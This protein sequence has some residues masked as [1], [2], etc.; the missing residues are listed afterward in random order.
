MLINK[1]YHG[2]LR[3]KIPQPFSDFGLKSSWPK[4]CISASLSNFSL[5]SANKNWMKLTQLRHNCDICNSFIYRL[6]LNR[7]PTVVETDV[8]GDV[9]TDDIIYR[10]GVITL[11][12]GW[13]NG[14]VST[15]HLFI[16][17]HVYISYIIDQSLVLFPK[18]FRIWEVY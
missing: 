8:V 18:L 2:K 14:S 6:V 3:T 12:E 7:V 13:K 17:K 15:V 11:V 16:S 5:V 1:T 9:A 4:F 10:Q